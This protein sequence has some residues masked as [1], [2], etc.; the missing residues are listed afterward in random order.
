MRIT[1][2]RRSGPSPLQGAR[3]GLA[4]SLALGA[5]C[6]AAFAQGKSGLGPDQLQL[7]SGPGTVTGYGAEYDKDLPSGGASMEI[8]I[9]V[10]RGLA[11]FQPEVT[12]AY[13]SG[14]GN[15]PLGY[16]WD[17]GF[18]QLERRS[19]LPLPRYV[20]GPNGIDDD[21][22]GTIDEDDEVDKVRVF[23]RGAPINLISEDDLDPEDDLVPQGNGFFFTS[24]EEDFVRYE[25][26]DDYWRGVQPDG[27]AFDFGLTEQ[28][29]VVDPDDPS[30]VFAWQ[31]EREH[32][33]SGNVIEYKY[34]RGDTES[35][36]GNLYIDEIQYGLGEPPWDNF[37][38]VKFVYEERPDV[39]ETGVTG[40]ILREGLRM[41]AIVTGTQIESMPGHLQGDFNDDGT[42]DFLNSRYEIRYETHPYWSLISSITKVGAD[43][44]T[45]MPPVSLTWTVCDP[46]DVIDASDA[47]IGVANAP[48]TLPNNPAAAFT[49]LNGDGLPDIL[50]T[51]PSG[52][53][54]RAYLNLGESTGQDGRVI[55]WSSPQPVGGDGRTYTVDLANENEIA[56]LVDMDADGRSDLAYTAGPFDT[57]YFGQK[58]ENGLPVW[59]PRQRMNLFQGESAP[60]S[61]YGNPNVE[62]GDWNGDKN[63]D[64]AQ[65]TSVGAG[66]QIRIWYNLGGERFSRPVTYPQEFPY[67]LAME[68]VSLTD[69]NGDGLDDF[70]RIR[71]NEIEVWP[72]LG[73]GRF[74]EKRVAQIPDYTLLNQFIERAEL[75]DITGDGFPEL[76]IDQPEPGV[77]WY[78]IGHGDYTFEKRRIIT[79]LPVPRGNN[80]G[81]DVADL[82]GNGT[83][84][85]VY[86]D[87]ASGPRLTVVDIAELLYTAS[88]SEPG[89]TRK[90]FPAPNL[91]QEISNGHGRRTVYTYASSTEF[92]LADAADGEP[93]TD[94]LP[95]TVPV[96]SRVDN[97]D[98]FGNEYTELYAYRDG[99]YDPRFRAFA[100]FGGATFE[101][102]GEDTAPTERIIYRFDVGKGSTALRGKV[103]EERSETIDGLIQWIETTEYE[104]RELGEGDSPEPI[105]TAF[106]TRITREIRESGRGEPKFLEKEFVYDNFGNVLEERDYGIVVD[107]DRSAFN[108][109]VITKTE[110]AKNLDDWLVVYPFRVEIQDLDGNVIKR[111]ETYYDDDT[112]EGSNPGEVFYAANNVE[113]IWVN[114]EE[115]DGFVTTQRWIWDDYGNIG[116]YLDGL[117]EIEDGDVTEDTGNYRYIEFDEIFRSSPVRET[118]YRGGELDPLVIEADYDLGFGTVIASRDFNGI[119]TRYEYDAL[120]RPTRVYRPGDVEDFPSVEYAY[121]LGVS[122]GTATVNWVETRM[123]DRQANTP[124]LDRDGH[125][126][127]T[128]TYINGLGETILEKEE[129]EANPESG[130]PR[131]VGKSA[132]IFN[133]RGK[134]R[135]MLNP[136]YTTLSGSLNDML[137]FE[138]VLEPSWSGLFQTGNTLTQLSLADSHRVETI[139]DVE[140]RPSRV[141]TQDR[142]YRE[143]VYEPLLTRQYDESDTD[144]AS[145]YFDTPLVHHKDGQDRIVQVDEVTRMDDTGVLTG[146]LNS[147]STTYAYRADGARTRITDS[148]GNVR[149]MEYDGLKRLTILN[150]PNQGIV[151]FTYDAASN[152][153]SRTD[154]AGRTTLFGYDTV[155]RKV[156]EDQ[157][158]ED[159]PYSLGFAYDPEQPLDETNR[160][161]VVYFYDDPVVDLDMGDG[162]TDTATNTLGKLATVWDQAGEHHSSYDDRGRINWT[163][164][165]L[166]DPRSG[167]LASYRTGMA[168]DTMDRVTEV[169]YPDG[170]RADYE[171]NDRS[172]VERISGGALANAGGIAHV[173]AATSYAPTGQRLSFAYGNG[174]STSFG[175]DARKRLTQLR[176]I[177]ANRDELLQYQY[178]F[179]AVSNITQVTDLRPEEILPSG[180]ARRNHQ[181]FGYDDLYRITS[182]AY[183]FDAVPTGLGAAG[184]IS[185]RYDRIGNLAAQTSDIDDLE[186]RFSKV[187]LG[188]LSYGGPLGSSGRVGRAV[189]DPPGPSALTFLDDGFFT[190][191]FDYDAMGNMTSLG[192][193]DMTWNFANQMVAAENALMRAEYRYDYSGE[194]VLKTI[195][196]KDDDGQVADTPSQVVQYVAKYFEVREGE[197]PVKYIYNGEDRLARALGTLDPGVE[198]VQR[199][200][201]AAGWN[202]AAMGVEAADASA[203]LKI[204]LSPTLTAAFLWDASTGDYEELASD[205]PLPGG[206]VFW[207]YADEAH[208]ASVRGM[209]L[210][211]PESAPATPGFN[212]LRALQASLP[213]VAL[214]DTL[215]YVWGYD[216]DAQEWRARFGGENSFLSEFPAFIAPGQP[217]Y[218]AFNDPATLALGGPELDLHYY[219]EDHL[220]SASLVTAADGSLL[221][222]TAFYPFGEPRNQFKTSKGE[223]TLPNPYL[224]SQ[225][226]RDAESGLQ[227][228][229]ARYLAATLARFNRVDPMVENP[230]DEAIA[231]PQL[232]NAYSYARNNPLVL[233]DP[234]GRFVRTRAGKVLLRQFNPFSDQASGNLNDNKFL[235]RARVFGAL[236]VEKGGKLFD[237]GFSSGADSIPDFAQ[238]EIAKLKNEA[239]ASPNKLISDV[240]QVALKLKKANPDNNKLNV[241]SFLQAITQKADSKGALGASLL[242]EFGQ[243]GFDPK[244]LDDSSITKAGSIVNEGIA[245]QI[246][247]LQNTIKGL[248][249]QGKLKELTEKGNKGLEFKDSKGFKFNQS[250]VDKFIDKFL[251]GADAL[252]ELNRSKRDSDD[253]DSDDDGPKD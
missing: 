174:V 89:S 32:D 223:A 252:T 144:P 95:F 78:W 91:L 88:P 172:L 136:Y 191:G 195:Y 124:D 187:N 106:P 137:A 153:T 253:S 111:T 236:S 166:I 139:Y 93:W 53:E 211:H 77:L 237:T 50:V 143:T 199:F 102:V 73:Y 8:P 96:V 63:G 181:Q 178:D 203:Q 146:D 67:N 154:A 68:G 107:G 224:F 212:A 70:V 72:G 120:A 65:S 234:D 152:M 69:F 18:Y 148:Q 131:V 217:V 132:V 98:S 122:V 151:T 57:Y 221:E 42:P 184:S 5:L 21:F 229:E 24:I 185:Y 123:L 135:Y 216:A 218:L 243:R 45:A 7:P 82:N 190:R 20:D 169:V 142:S 251:G 202:L 61:P 239:T 47:H 129:A 235:R 10:P 246:G 130:D 86:I 105:E 35:T 108:D 241:D 33:L 128:R 94:A 162:T 116:W 227:Y 183:G 168:Y 31:L 180:D 84:D 62:R 176:T 188:E 249:V 117:A 90:V 80:P 23:L 197:Q 208:H 59:G 175:Y 52:G 140:L 3:A 215:D 198:R 125:Y 156:Y 242:K 48:L 104:V 51:N 121:A 30:R 150:E 200:R 74:A 219:H 171:Y 115:P 25:K 4:L 158:D 173:L 40:F 58:I 232:L 147:W 34:R 165:S 83:D 160:P 113:F 214:P 37:H 27:Y 110:Y 207:V 44:L 134:V 126:R 192:E 39:Y 14:G 141:Y 220:G 233:V 26:V 12:L 161:D 177:D 87:N 186:G 66:S 194:R 193:L 149:L 210:A 41:T 205:S 170:D 17:I 119:E 196:P 157:L 75:D 189:D 231:D 201:F 60:P 248:D 38:F 138:N 46:P 19:S 1:R 133:G 36:R 6:P 250:D 13:E 99:Y 92:L 15:S 9:D 118:I 209:P 225:K 76:V 81:T 97:Y 114:P 163:L 206:S 127:F 247:A 112:L 54:H 85:R 55:N 145:P 43:G 240:E 2:N 213:E 238:K 155:N 226:E 56:E 29:R 167:L 28:S 204:G 11:D 64:I 230:P 22:D 71:P 109:E 228:F 49:E 245:K 159:Q 101:D 222:E 244:N 179:D 182:A 164:R 103:L 100:G 16:G 79:G